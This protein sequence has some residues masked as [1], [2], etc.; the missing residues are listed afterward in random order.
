MEA[1][2]NGGVS[3]T[4]CRRAHRASLA[5]PSIRNG[6]GDLAPL[7]RPACPNI[8]PGDVGGVAPLRSRRA[9]GRFAVSRASGVRR[10]SPGSTRMH[11]PGDSER[12]SARRG[13][14][15]DTL[16]PVGC[17]APPRSRPSTW[18]ISSPASRHRAAP[19]E[20]RRVKNARPICRRANRPVAGGE[21]GSPSTRPL[22]R[23]IQRTHS[24]RRSRCPPLDRVVIHTRSWAETFDI[25]DVEASR[26]PSSTASP[27]T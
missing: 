4:R 20:A 27:R 16:V 19:H 6:P 21:C 1:G 11:I 24:P 23:D 5:S 14:G 13:C 18:S 2:P 25:L 12:S 7:G 22:A 3:A 9:H 8:D 26:R 17:T 10:P 15:F